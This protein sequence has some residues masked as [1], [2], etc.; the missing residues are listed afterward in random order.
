MEQNF[1]GIHSKIYACSLSVFIGKTLSSAQ[2]SE[3]YFPNPFKLQEHKVNMLSLGD[4]SGRGLMLERYHKKPKYYAL[5]MHYKTKAMLLQ[6]IFTVLLCSCYAH[7][8]I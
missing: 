1:S 4:R 8:R 5:T 6:C 7:F 3:K 2:K